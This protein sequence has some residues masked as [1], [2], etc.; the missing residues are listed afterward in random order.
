MI[1]AWLALIVTVFCSTAGNTLANWSHD[2]IGRKRLVVL[3]SAIGVHGF[4][5]LSFAVALTGIPLAIAYPVL[6]GGSVG[7]VTL[8]AVL[9]FGERLSPRHFGGL[10][11]IIVG[12]ILLQ[13]VHGETKTAEAVWPVRSTGSPQ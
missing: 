2:F 13:G 11:L 5:L 9:L 12:L 1:L 10:A 7:G 4:G 3:S 8:L 6:I